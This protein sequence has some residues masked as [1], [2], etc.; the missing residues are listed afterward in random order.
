[1]QTWCSERRRA[2][3]VIE[4]A[5]ATFSNSSSKQAAYYALLDIQGSRLDA[6]DSKI[7]KYG[8]LITKLY[9]KHITTDMLNQ[10]GKTSGAPL[11][12]K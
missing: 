12:A 11:E 10:T 1:M 5:V 6:L 8:P 3:E 7:R 2:L 4:Q 9:E